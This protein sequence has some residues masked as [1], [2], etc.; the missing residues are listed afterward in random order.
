MP[1]LD[2]DGVGVY[3]EVAG[4]GPVVLLT[5]AYSSDHRLWGPTVPALAERYRVVTWDLRGHGDSDAPE[6]PA[7]YTV[8]KVMGDMSALLDEVG[9]Q[10]AVIGGLSLGGFL[11]LEFLLAHRDRAAALLLVSTGPGFRKDEAREQWN[12]QAERYAQRYDQKG[13]DALPSGRETAVTR[14][15]SAAGLA[16]A[17]RGYFMQRDARVIDSLPTLDL[18]TLVVVGADDTA[19]HPASAYMAGKIPG[20][21]KVELP[22]A[23]HAANIDQP[24]PFNDAVLEWLDSLPSG[25]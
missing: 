18:P 21:R 23:G 16:R 1:K 4:D 17:S 3:Y 7:E 12:Q 13:L 15:R 22:D 8:E 2:R 11:S 19:Y 14:H 20:A 9:A 25:R 24:E 5:H 6:D 10:Q